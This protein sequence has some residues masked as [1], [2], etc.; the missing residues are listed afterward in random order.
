MAYLHSRTYIHGDLRSPNVFVTEDQHLKIGDF[1]F[2]RI[3]GTANEDGGEGV[4]ARFT[5]PRWQAPEV[6]A[7]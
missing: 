2:A 6:R 4:P 1:G 7:T 3:I 5:N